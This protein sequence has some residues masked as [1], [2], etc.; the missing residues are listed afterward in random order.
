MN[1]RFERFLDKSNSLWIGS[2]GDGILKIHNY[3]VNKNLNDCEVELINKSNNAINDNVIYAFGKSK[4]IY[5]GLVVKMG[6]IIIHIK[7]KN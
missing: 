5:Y 3:N 7:Q 4:K 6:Y 1:V 2:K